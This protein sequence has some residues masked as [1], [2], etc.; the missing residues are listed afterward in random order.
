MKTSICVLTWLVLVVPCQARI[1][2]VDC[3]GGGDFDTI[4]AAIDDANNGDVV[5][6]FVASSLR[7]H[8]TSYRCCRGW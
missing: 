2:T 5:G 3:N 4:Q 7:F 6:W 1:I 8:P